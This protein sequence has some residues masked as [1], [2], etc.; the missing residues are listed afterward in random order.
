MFTKADQLLVGAIDMHAHGYPQF[1]LNL[2]ARVDDYEWAE[3]AADAGMA[4]FV[5][6]SHMWPTMSSAYMIN[7][8]FDEITAYG[9]ITLNDIVGGINPAY[10]EVA[11]E[12]GAK[13]VFMPTWSGVND[14]DHGCHFFNRMR[15]FVSRID[16]ALEGRGGVPTLDANGNLLPNVIEVIEV[17][18]EYDLVLASGHISIGESL[19]LAEQAAKTGVKFVLTHPLLSP[20]IAATHEQMKEVANMGGYIEHVFV[21]CMPMHNRMNPHDIYDAIEY[22]GAEHCIMSSDAIEGW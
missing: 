20:L 8:L 9:S 16:G 11:A 6:K 2:P 17:C 4:G 15:P 7:K 22:V 3:A 14:V 18:K 10:V 12:S 19:K 21:G 1:S 13:V 5:I